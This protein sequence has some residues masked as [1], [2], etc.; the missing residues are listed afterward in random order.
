MATAVHETRVTD[1][2]YSTGRSTIAMV[3]LVM[4]VL[5][6][7]FLRLVNPDY[8]WRSFF[9]T[10]LTLLLGAV[11]FWAYITARRSGTMRFSPL[12]VAAI[13]LILIWI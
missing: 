6:Q 11:F 12:V 2:R 3:S 10:F 7:V 9:W 1:G 8:W 5:L 4:L 13:I